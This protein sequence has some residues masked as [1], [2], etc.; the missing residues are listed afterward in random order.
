ML[1][2]TLAFFKFINEEGPYNVAYAELYDVKLDFRF[3]LQTV[4]SLKGLC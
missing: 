4:L 2:Y 3:G 1:F